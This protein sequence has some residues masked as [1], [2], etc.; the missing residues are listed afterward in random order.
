MECVERCDLAIELEPE[1]PRGRTEAARGSG[2]A[3]LASGRDSE[4]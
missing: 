4:D 3:E 2:S 1:G